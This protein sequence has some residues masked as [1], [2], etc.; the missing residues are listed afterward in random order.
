MFVDDPYATSAIKG[1]VPDWYTVYDTQHFA[2][3]APYTASE[4][5]T[6]AQVVFYLRNVTDS[7]PKFFFDN[8]EFVDVTP[9]VA[10]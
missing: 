4:G 10:R 7:R 6:A 2:P 5:C 9:G 1:P 3:P 8:V